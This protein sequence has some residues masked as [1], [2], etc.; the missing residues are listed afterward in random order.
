MATIVI[1]PSLG[2]DPVKGPGLRLHG[3]TR[4]NLEKFFFLG[5]NILYEKIKKQSIWI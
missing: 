5:F 2:V 1:K 3:L 4:V